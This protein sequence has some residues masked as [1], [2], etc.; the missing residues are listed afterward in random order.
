MQRD[1][2]DSQRPAPQDA[3]RESPTVNDPIAR[4]L[5]RVYDDVANEPLPDNLVALL[6]KLKQGGRE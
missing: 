2:D 5:K 6:D 1:H 4:S 3:E